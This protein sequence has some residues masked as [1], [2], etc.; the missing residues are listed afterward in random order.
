[1]KGNI[2]VDE[3]G[4]EAVIQQVGMEIGLVIEICLRFKNRK[5]DYP[6]PHSGVMALL[7]ISLIKDGEKEVELVNTNKVSEVKD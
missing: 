2:E 3:T 7:Y 4:V 1:M 6:H 5:D